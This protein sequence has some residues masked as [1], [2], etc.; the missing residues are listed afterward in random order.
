MAPRIAAR[1]ALIVA[2]VVFASTMLLVAY[3]GWRFA[4][5]NEQIYAI[6][7]M[8]LIGGSGTIAGLAIAWATRTHGWLRDTS[9]L[10]ATIFTALFTVLSLLTFFSLGILFLPMA[11]ALVGLFLV[12]VKNRSD[13][14]K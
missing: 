7:I 1:A 13:A 6:T 10:A 9:Q 3:P 14:S 8:S 12:S 4:T 11:L 2:L 5:R